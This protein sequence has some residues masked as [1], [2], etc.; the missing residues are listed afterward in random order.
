LVIQGVDTLPGGAEVT[1]HGD[2]RIAMTL[3]IAATR[4]Q[5]PIILDDPDCVAK[6]Y[7]EFWQDY[8]KLGG[9]IAVI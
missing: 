6:S 7:P 8:Q 3:A 1:S 9:R 5:Q 4:C 2:H